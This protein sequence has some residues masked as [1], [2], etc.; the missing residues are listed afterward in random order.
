MSVEP[1]TGVDRD[2]NPVSQHYM[3]NITSTFSNK[4]RSYI[5][6]LYELTWSFKKSPCLYVGNSQGGPIYEVEDP[7][8]PIIEGDYNKY[9]VDDLFSEDNFAYGMFDENNCQ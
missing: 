6:R 1:F 7:N 5:G 3:I 8:D 4:M 2:G 9:I